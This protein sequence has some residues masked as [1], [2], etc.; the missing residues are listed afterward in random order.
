MGPYVIRRLLQTVPT[1]IGITIITFLVMRVGGDPASV[2]LG[3]TAT[4]EAVA[5][6]R[7]EHGYDRPVIV[8][9]LTYMADALTGDLGTSVRYGV[10]VAELLLARLPATLELGLIAVVLTVF[11]AIPIGVLAALRPSGPLDVMARSLALLGQAVPGFFLGIVLIL[12]FAVT[13]GWLPT[14]GRGTAAHVVL[15]AATLAAFMIALVVR[16]TRSSMRDVLRQDFVRTARAKGVSEFAIVRKH[17]TRN[18]L[19]PI[20]TVIGLQAAAVFSGAL[21]TETVFSW[22][23]VGRLMVQ[24]VYSRDLP[25][26][27]ATVMFGTLAVVAVNLV[28]DIAYGLI[29]PRVRYE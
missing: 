25:L 9:Y 5:A 20:I 19:I 17:V 10:P 2:V 29:D 6:Y 24:A 14:G 18:A 13:L 7:A 15:P 1:I 8:Q 12:V 26:V 22:P 16:F 11:I 4:R 28:V 3:E 23:G 27:Q 21:V